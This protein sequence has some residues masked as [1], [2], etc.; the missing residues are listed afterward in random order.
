MSFISK[1]FRRS[2]SVQPTYESI[3]DAVA[4]AIAGDSSNK[5]CVTDQ[6]ALSVTTVWACVSLLSESVGVLPIH[7]YKHTDNGR[8]KVESHPSLSLIRYPN[9]YTSRMEMMQ[10][11]MVSVALYGNGYAQIIRDGDGKAVKLKMLDPTVPQP[12]LSK[13]G[14]ELFYNVAGKR[15]H[16]DN[17]IHIKGLV[18]DGLKG[19][20]PISVH[21]ENLELSMNVQAYGKLFFSNGGNTSAVFEIPGTLR[22]DAYKR[23]KADLLMRSSGMNNAHSPLLLEGGMKYSRVNIPLDDAQFLSTRKFQKGEIASIYRIPPHMVGDLERATYSNIEQQ[24]QEFVTYCLMPYLEK[25]ESELNRKLLRYDE[26]DTYYFRFTINGLLR[27]DS[28]SRSEFYKN[29][30]MIGCMNANE[31]RQMEEMNSYEGGEKFFVQQNMATTDNAIKQNNEQG[32]N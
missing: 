2:E 32:N 22:E 14:D 25:I 6:T 7:L 30:Y 10:H 21:R 23:L 8:E 9:A 20:S 12:Y 29:M 28:K 17:M 31:I 4:R 11:L 18:V 1:I 27:A 3:D 15:V 24:G 13:N 16:S 19:K 5:V 26:Q